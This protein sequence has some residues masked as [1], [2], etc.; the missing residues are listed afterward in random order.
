M[1][2]DSVLFISPGPTISW[3]AVRGKRA[4]KAIRSG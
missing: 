3:A 4:A 2:G 1:E